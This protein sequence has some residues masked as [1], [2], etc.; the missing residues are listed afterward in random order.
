V[1]FASQRE[2]VKKNPALLERSGREKFADSGDLDAA[3]AAAQLWKWRCR[4]K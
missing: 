2:V 3:K 4:F 1:S